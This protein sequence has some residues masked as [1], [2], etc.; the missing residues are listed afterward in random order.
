MAAV[1]HTAQLLPFI[2]AMPMPTATL[3]LT[4]AGGPS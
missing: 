2:L 3:L 4:W 1:T